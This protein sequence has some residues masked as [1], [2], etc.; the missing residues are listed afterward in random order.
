MKKSLKLS[1]AAVLAA[2]VLSFVSPLRP[3]WAT[4]LGYWLY[5]VFGL[6]SSQTMTSAATET[7]SGAVTFSGTVTNTGNRLAAGPAA[8]VIAAG[9]TIIA[10][11]CGGTKLISSAGVVSSSTTIPFT[12]PAAANT[13]CAMD[14]LNVGGSS[15]T[16]KYT[17]GLGGFNSA[18]GADVVLGS[19]DTVRV[20]ST[21]VSWFQVGTTGNN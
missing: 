10:N 13:G 3:A 4:S 20:I 9:D 15:I 17:A 21:G 16:I 5:P 14:V 12:T 11:A 2:V 8:Q 7:H 6:S 18:L 1:A 19:S